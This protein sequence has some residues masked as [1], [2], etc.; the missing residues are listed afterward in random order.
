MAPP[1]TPQLA[2]I[3]RV[4]SFD[5]ELQ[6]GKGLSRVLRP[7][8]GPFLR[9]AGQKH[10]EA[11]PAEGIHGCGPVGGVAQRLARRSQN[12]RADRFAVETQNGMIE[13]EIHHDQRWRSRFSS[14]PG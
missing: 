6:L 4:C 10:H 1:A 3:R 9:D 2:A 14:R 11:V 8:H 7:R 5:G 12:R 13:V